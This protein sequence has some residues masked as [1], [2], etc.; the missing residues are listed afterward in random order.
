MEAFETISTMGEEVGLHLNISKCEVGF[1]GGSDEDRILASEMFLSTLPGIQLIQNKSATLLGC[2]L[3]IEAIP[4]VINSKTQ[5]MEKLSSRL[6]DISAHSAFYLLR[7]S[8]SIPRLIYFLRCCPSWKAESSL[9]AYDDCL[10]QS[11]EKIL[12]VR[13]HQDAWNQ[14][15]LPVKKGGLGIRHAVDMALP[16][17]LSS[18]FA[19]NSIL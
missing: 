11:L 9:K 18:F 16:C 6:N 4:P 1:I 14:S 10:K 3:T 17:F 12:N 15:G 13:L 7:A 19:C 2:P 8:I 5:K